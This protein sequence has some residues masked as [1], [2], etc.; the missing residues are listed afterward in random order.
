VGARSGGRRAAADD[1]SW[2][3]PFDAKRAGKSE[4]TTSAGRR[5][6]TPAAKPAAAPAR[7]G[8]WQDPFT[9]DAPARPARGAVAMRDRDAKDDGGKWQAAAKHGSSASADESGSPSHSGG[10]GVLKKRR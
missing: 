10:W 7:G 8:K 1:D 4:K 3:D 5:V 2:D 6:V 9:E